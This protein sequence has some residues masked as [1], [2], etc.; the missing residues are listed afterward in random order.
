M[1]E[2]TTPRLRLLSLSYTQLLILAEGRYALEDF[3]GLNRSVFELNTG[4]EF[5]AEFAEAIKSYSIPKVKDHREEYAWFTHWLIIHK[6]QNLTIGGIG[7]T[8]LPDEDGQVMLGYFTDKKY[9]GKG[10]ATEALKALLDWM[11]LHPGLHSVIADTVPGNTG[12]EKVLL[13]NGFVLS[14]PVEEGSRWEKRR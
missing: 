11:F 6:E 1:F 12:S 5:L 13:K 7:G 9:E 10:F 14:G 4:P 3:L 8:G 2:I